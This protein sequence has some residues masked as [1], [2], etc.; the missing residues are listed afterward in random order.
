[1]A[2]AVLLVLGAGFC[3]IQAGRHY[4]YSRITLRET[5]ATVIGKQY[6]RFDEPNPS[7][8]DGSGDPITVKPGDE[9]WRVYYLIDS[10]DSLDNSVRARLLRDEEQRKAS[11]RSRFRFKSREWYEKIEIGD[12]LRVLY[13]WHG[14]NSV[15]IIYVENPKY[16]N[17]Q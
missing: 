11:N 13:Q 9:Q 12:K 17:L 8:D 4:L 14:G 16:P 7:Y 15:D 5:T 3:A 10:F 6:V 1:M 2:G